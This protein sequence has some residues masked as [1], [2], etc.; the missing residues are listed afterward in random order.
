[1]TGASFVVVTGGAAAASAAASAALNAS[2]SASLA[3]GNQDFWALVARDPHA[4]PLAAVVVLI[5][6]AA[7]VATLLH[8]AFVLWIRR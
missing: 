8:A 1:M 5:G 2:T 3:A 4:G 6:M 7:T